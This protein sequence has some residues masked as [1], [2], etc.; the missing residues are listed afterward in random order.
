MSL[1]A[2]RA[3]A[4]KARGILRLPASTGELKMTHCR[5]DI[6]ALEARAFGANLS[7]G[8]F[9]SSEDTVRYG[10]GISIH[11]TYVSR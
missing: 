2:L 11:D 4:K 7:L 8:N 10:R 5:V 6:F 9:G 1:A 3:C